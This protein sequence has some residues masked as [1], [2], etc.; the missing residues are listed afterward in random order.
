M[1]GG[2]WSNVS[3]GF[4]N[5]GDENGGCTVIVSNRVVAAIIIA[6]TRFKSFSILVRKRKEEIIFKGFSKLVINDLL[7]L[8]F[9]NWERLDTFFDTGDIS[10]VQNRDNRMDITVYCRSFVV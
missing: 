9:F 5:I 1:N 8:D 10:Q 2:K 6:I 7:A 3:S 4:I